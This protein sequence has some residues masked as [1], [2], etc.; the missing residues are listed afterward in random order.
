MERVVAQ[1]MLTR[2]RLRHNKLLPL[3]TLNKLDVPVDVVVLGATPV[4]AWLNEFRNHTIITLH[5]IDFKDRTIS[6]GIGAGF[7]MFLKLTIREMDSPCF[8]GHI[9]GMVEDFTITQP[10]G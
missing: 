2:K 10:A 9:I 1:C 8:D 3:T 4:F 5:L 7:G 6:N